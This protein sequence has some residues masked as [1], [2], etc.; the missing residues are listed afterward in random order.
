VP[1][2]LVTITTFNRFDE[3]HL[4]KGA[5]ASAGIES[6]VVHENAAALDRG[7]VVR[8]QVREEDA[9]EADMIINRIQGLDHAE[10]VRPSDVEE[11]APPSRCE[12]CGSADV[13]RIN[14]I[15]QFGA[16]TALVLIIFGY[17]QQTLFAFYG[18]VVI[19]VVILVR[20]RWECARC[21][22]HW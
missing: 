17:F 1:S 13:R 12:R 2:R 5:L 18:I 19:G 8:L 4:A 21:G 7:H 20:G 16:A 15:L 3:A 14:K 11:A 10:F 22:Y 6:V 9:E